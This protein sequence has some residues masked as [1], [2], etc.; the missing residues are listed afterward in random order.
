MDQLG[1]DYCVCD[2]ALGFVHDFT[3]LHLPNCSMP[4][5]FLLFMFITITCGTVFAFVIYLQTLKLA[6]K[7]VKFLMHLFMLGT[8]LTWCISLSLYL[9]D[10][11]YV[12]GLVFTA[13]MVI[14]FPYFVYHLTMFMLRPA[15]AAAQR[16]IAFVERLLQIVLSVFSLF[17]V[18][19]V[20]IASAYA[21]K[22]E[23]RP[24]YHV[25]IS[26]SLIPAGL[27]FASFTIIAATACKRLMRAVEELSVLHPDRFDIPVLRARLR[28]LFLVL[29]AVFVMGAGVCLASLIQFSLG[30][31]PYMYVI[32]LA[33]FHHPW[34]VGVVVWRCVGV[35][36]W[37][38]A[39]R[40]EPRRV[41]T[42]EQRRAEIAARDRELEAQAVAQRELRF[43]GLPSMTATNTLT[44][45][46]M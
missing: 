31:F 29:F 3:F 25:A 14:V 18:I 44:S 43:G 33:I 6:K 26:G 20:L 34:I 21:R 36:A 4:H 9:Q 15:F 16:N 12:A 30:S 38:V 23:E 19:P 10:G 32:V 8:A 27:A 13:L 5:W 24:H 17:I 37:W 46:Q 28:W 22:E 40:D 35:D 7:E 45:Y 41:T 1:H 42:E 11:M 39:V 2:P